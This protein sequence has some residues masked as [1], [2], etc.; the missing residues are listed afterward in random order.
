VQ[1]SLT[2][3]TVNRE[4]LSMR[5]LLGGLIAF[6]MLVFAGAARGED[7]IPVGS[8]WKWLHPTDGVD[9]G[10]ADKEFHAKWFTV[11]FDDEKWKTGK[12]SEGEHGGF[13]Y[14][15]KDFEGV[16]I[17]APDAD[18]PVDITKPVKRRTAYFRHAFETKEE[19][20]SLVLK[21]QRD[22]GIVIYLDGKEVARDN[23][24]LDKDAYDLMAVTTTADVEETKVREY[25]LKG[26]LKPGK[27]LLA[28]SLHN[29]AG[30]SS[31]L[32][33][34]EISL[35]EPKPEEEKTEE[36]KVEAPKAE[37]KKPT[38]TKPTDDKTETPEKKDEAE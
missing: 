26:P 1:S 5:K 18:D 36:K 15:E 14:G 32:R 29:R 12:D 19:V 11:E 4:D 38:E 34:A 37:E 33:I 30:G 25:K 35:G 9:P 8:E 22:D 3:D 13:G 21:L 10:K 28:I 23:V 2:F 24:G 20:P 31:D 6:S 7:L 16:D 27:H 17:G